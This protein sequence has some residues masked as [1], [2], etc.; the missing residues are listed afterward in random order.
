MDEPTDH[1]S[2]WTFHHPKFK[3]ICLMNNNT[4]EDPR[5]RET[6]EEIWKE[7]LI[8][9]DMS[10]Y[11]A[12][13]MT[14]ESA[15][16]L[17]KTKWDGAIHT[18]WDY[19]KDE[20]AVLR[21]I[22]LMIAAGIRPEIIHCYIL[23]GYDTTEEEDIYRIRKLRRQGVLP[24]VMPFDKKKLSKEKSYAKAFFRKA[25]RPAIIKQINWEKV[26][27]WREAVNYK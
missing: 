17:A 9:K 22:R 20:K 15:E 1:R 26:N 12:R 18:A 2:I 21:G 25:T 8:M 5:W 14:E 23:V 13:L 3:K 4:L 16:C 11:D 10:G 7:K 27:D 24:F 6:F 19:L